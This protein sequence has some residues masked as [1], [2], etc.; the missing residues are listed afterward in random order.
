MSNENNE[1]KESYMETY[2][3]QVYD[4]TY[5]RLADGTSVLTQP[6][7]GVD[8]SQNPISNTAY[9]GINQLMLQQERKDHNLKSPYWVSGS[10][11][12]Q[13]W[14][15]TMKAGEVGTII[16]FMNKDGKKYTHDYQDPKTGHL[17]KQG[18][19]VLN[20]NGERITQIEHKTVFHVSQLDMRQVKNVQEVI[21]SQKENNNVPIIRGKQVFAPVEKINQGPVFTDSAKPGVHYKAKDDSPHEKV[22]ESMSAYLNS[23][24]TGAEYPG[25]KLNKKEIETVLTQVNETMK[26]DPNFIMKVASV[27]GFSATGKDKALEPQKAPEKAKEQNLEPKKQ[28]SKAR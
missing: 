18:T 27:A 14:G 15:V 23:C 26:Q 28:Q 16:Q 5:G 7:S 22:I 24:Y 17:H 19:Y 10:Q 20:S 12:L 8:Y 13:E 1:K 2:R 11:P 9:V 3:K 6:R 25:L 21:E 4:L